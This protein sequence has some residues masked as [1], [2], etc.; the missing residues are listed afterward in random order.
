MHKMLKTT[1]VLGLAGVFT[2]G[3]VLCCCVRRIV[4]VKA[5]VCC[6]S[7]HADHKA[8]DCGSCASSLKIAEAAH[9][10]DFTSSLAFTFKV[11][12]ADTAFVPRFNTAVYQTAWINGPPG[13]SSVVPLYTQF[14]QFRI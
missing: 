1:L 6:A 11:L 5:H 13:F 9:S 14:H 2:I 12:P 7:K 3:A 4:P 10:F 8:A